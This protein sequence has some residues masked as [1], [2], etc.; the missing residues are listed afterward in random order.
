MSIRLLA[1]FATIAR[2]AADGCN[3]TSTFS[4]ANKAYAAADSLDCSA[5]RSPYNFSIVNP[6]SRDLR[7][8]ASRGNVCIYYRTLGAYS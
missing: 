1:F 7:V 2:V 3:A 6:R 4:L 5:A 8:F